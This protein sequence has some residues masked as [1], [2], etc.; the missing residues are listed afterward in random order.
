MKHSR[1]TAALGFMLGLLLSTQAVAQST[2]SQPPH[3]SL[4][5]VLSERDESTSI[6]RLLELWRERDRFLPQQTSDALRAISNAGNAHPITR[7]A[8]AK[9]LAN[10]LLSQGDLGAARAQVESLGYI[11]NW[12]VIGPFDNE[13]KQGFD[14]DFGL[15]QD[16]VSAHDPTLTL[17]GRER[18]V[19]W[20]AFPETPP[21]GY[22]ELSSRLR[23]NR[24]VCAYAMTTIESDRAQPLSL[25]LSSAGAMRVWWNGEVVSEDAAYRG[26]SSIPRSIVSVG[27]HRGA[28]RLVIKVCAADRGWSF[29]ARLA[30]GRGRP[31]QNLRIAPQS[32][33]AAVP[34]HSRV[35]R[36]ALPTPP[37]QTLQEAA[38]SEQ[39]GPE[40]W[41]NF[42]RFLHYTNSDD[43]AERQAPQ[44]AE[45]AAQAEPNIKR[46]QLILS[47]VTNRPQ[48][49]EWVGRAEALFPEQ[50]D[51]SDQRATQVRLL[52]AA[53]MLNSTSPED[54]LHL[55][56][57]REGDLSPEVRNQVA[58]LRA[59]YQQRLG[60]H[61]AAFRTIETTARRDLGGS[62]GNTSYTPRWSRL[63]ADYAGRAHFRDYAV[64]AHQEVLRL[65]YDA[66]A[67][68][69][70]LIGDAIR[71]GDENTAHALLQEHEAL[72]GYR[73]PVQLYLATQYEALGDNEEA[74][75]RLQ[76]ARTIAPEEASSLVALGR[77]LLRQNRSEQAVAALTEALRLRPQDPSTRELLTQLRPA[78]RP[79]EALATAAETFLARRVTESGYPLTTLQDLTVNTVY[80]NGLGSSFRQIVTQ[81]HDDQGARA[82]R[83]YQIQFDPSSQR[84][85]ILQARVYRTN[86]STL[87]AVRTFERQLGQPWYRIYYDTR[88]LVVVLPDIEAGD[89][90]ELQYR[91]DDIAHANLFADYYG[92]IQILQQFN[93][94]QRLDYVLVTPESRDFYFNEPDFP[95]LEREERVQDGTRLVHYFAEGIP[96]L[97]QEQA[98]PG[99]TEVAPYL[100]VSTYQS[101]DDVGRWYWGLIQDQLYA[102]R[103]LREIVARLV[104]GAPDLRTKV[105]RIY[106][107]VL[108][109]TRYVGLEFGIHGFKPYRVP[110]VLRRGFGD[111]KDKASIIYT[112]LREAGIDAHIVLTRTRRNGDITDAPAS[113]AVFDHAIAYVP[114]L[115]LY[116]D[117]TAEHSGSTE[118]PTMDQGVTVLHVWPEGASLRRTP[119]LSP[120]QSHMTRS[121]DVTLANDGSATGTITRRVIGSGAGRY[122]SR[123]EAEGTRTERLERDLGAMFPGVTL[124]RQNFSDL[125]DIEE[126]INI[127]M[128]V[129]I[130]RFAS[131]AGDTLLVAPSV[132]QDLT[133]RLASQSTRNHTL[134]LGPGTGYTE[135]RRVRLAPGSRVRALPDGGSA[136]SEFGS[137]RVEIQQDRSAIR[138]ETRYEQ[139][140]AQVSP[141]QYEAFRQWVHEADA[142]L[143]QRI[144]IEGATP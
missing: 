80:P 93:P 29:Y 58:L 22:V 66:G 127:S 132:L 105:E 68:R 63:L 56:D 126:P 134:E 139:R 3:P 74:E 143:R 85:E 41:E 9:L 91:V 39:S 79:D 71:R 1:V 92:G 136:T 32:R 7:F 131:A 100:H 60:L 94:I 55:L 130:P 137:L 6:L 87:D 54:Y 111:C 95:L 21:L 16:L 84:V 138:V 35:R 83:S 2:P 5:G 82:W 116:L 73:V 144:E 51:S 53:I 44:F 89:V 42:A 67:S 99:F 18:P 98:M 23:P 36:P 103:N 28:N 59:K 10:A 133:T 76:A 121:I 61:S 38:E 90:V 104:Q 20:V 14:R 64:R 69:T 33:E 81:I 40:D 34:G 106:A 52:R 107:W 86:G 19:A 135:T 57:S 97:R 102:D 24:N 72:L 142:L 141:A 26:L 113:L 12:N 11:T 110:T 45:R 140:A 25:W 30:D 78:E 122:R 108:S 109:N 13:G 70:Y 124:E 62:L 88:A 31:T 115:D 27:A 123:F 96:A 128:Q 8:A 119:I 47:L 112:M 17:E 77:F 118:L 120:E 50:S 48:L 43:P 15:E 129:S 46:I 114:E 125:E 75:A 117:G 49:T 4:E 37:L 101:W 65:D